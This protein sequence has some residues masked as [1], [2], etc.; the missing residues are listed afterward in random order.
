MQQ[1]AHSRNGAPPKS[2]QASIDS[3]AVD[4]VLFTHMHAP[5]VSALRGTERSMLCLS[6]NAERPSGGFRSFPFDP[7][8]FAARLEEFDFERAPEMAPLGPC[9][10]VLGDGS[11]W[12]ISTPGPTIGCVSYLVLTV[13]GPLLVAGLLAE[14]LRSG[15]PA[16]AG[17]HKELGRFSLQRLRAFLDFYPAVRVA[18]GTGYESPTSRMVDGEE[19]TQ[20]LFE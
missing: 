15:E 19:V 12:A 5:Q 20:G 17:R 10:D 11:L 1:A 9:I 2:G 6:G 13:G 8:S 3:S 18:P 14:A 7:L 16:V 4:S